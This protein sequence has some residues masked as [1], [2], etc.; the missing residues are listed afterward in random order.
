MTD[1]AQ[2]VR[3]TAF[4]H[5]WCA[6]EPGTQEALLATGSD[7]WFRP[8]YV[9]HR[10]WVGVRLDGDAVDWQQVAELIAEGHRHVTA[11]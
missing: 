2:R 5:L 10:G 3:D 8:P 4:P 11:R 9:G 7:R 1:V 6:A